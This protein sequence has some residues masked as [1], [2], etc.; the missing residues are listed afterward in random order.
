MDTHSLCPPDSLESL[1]LV[2][3]Q[4]CSRKALEAWR[5]SA[6]SYVPL[7]LAAALAFHAGQ[8][9]ASGLLPERDYE[10][11]L[12]LAA[13]WL[14]RRVAVYVI[15]DS[16]KQLAVLDISPGGRFRDGGSVF[17]HR[18]GGCITS[19]GVT[20]TELA[21]LVEF[22]RRARWPMWNLRK[23]RHEAVYF[24]NN[25]LWNLPPENPYGA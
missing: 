23:N 16:K 4:H 22:I 5:S 14:S 3:L 21:P 11:A 1:A 18:P 20:R 19:L 10:L 8:E 12:N 9:C 7:S 24:A 17:Q 2:D 13:A 25:K 6:D 15:G